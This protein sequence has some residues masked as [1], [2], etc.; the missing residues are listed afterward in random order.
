M[1]DSR[2]EK[3]TAWTDKSYD[4][5]HSHGWVPIRLDSVVWH[6]IRTRSNMLTSWHSQ[7]L[8]L[9]NT[10]GL[11]FSHS[12]TLAMVILARRLKWES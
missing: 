2:Q 5:F 3:W 1:G 12:S 9:G 4:N 7:E 6:A 11:D 8:G 10:T